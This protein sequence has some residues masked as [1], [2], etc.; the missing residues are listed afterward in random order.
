[1]SQF[2][3]PLA[4]NQIVFHLRLQEYKCSHARIFATT[5]WINSAQMKGI[6]RPAF[7]A[8]LVTSVTMASRLSSLASELLPPTDRLLRIHLSI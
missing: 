4:F 1:M 2:I 3:E 6:D 8:G 7:A 5:G